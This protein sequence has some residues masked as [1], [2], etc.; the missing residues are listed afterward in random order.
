MKKRTIMMVLCQVI[1][2]TFVFGRELGGFLGKTDSC[3]VYDCE[4]IAKDFQD[5]QGSEPIGGCPTSSHNT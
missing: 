2:E 4:I 5:F 3:G 1:D